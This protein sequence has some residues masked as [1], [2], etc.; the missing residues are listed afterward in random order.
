MQ[1]RY[2]VPLLRQVLRDA[3]RFARQWGLDA[4]SMEPD[5]DGSSRVRI[6]SRFGGLA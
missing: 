6:R 3:W 5:S 1:Y 4:Q 2:I